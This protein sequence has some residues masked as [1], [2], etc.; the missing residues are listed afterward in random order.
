M[1]FGWLY[2]NRTQ[3]LAKKWTDQCKASTLALLVIAVY[4]ENKWKVDRLVD[5]YTELS[6]PDSFYAGC[7]ADP[8]RL[9]PEEWDIIQGHY[10][11]FHYR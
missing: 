2:R 3:R 8:F 10:T 9:S 7:E 5:S 6:K 4:Y 11:R 1:V